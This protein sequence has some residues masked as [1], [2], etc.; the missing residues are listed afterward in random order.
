VYET[1][2]AAEVGNSG[3]VEFRVFIPDATLDPSQYVAGGTPR[4]ARI[5]AVGTFQPTPWESSSGLVLERQRFQN[6]GYLY[7]A[8]T[9]PLATGFYEYKYDV[10]FEN[11]AARRVGDPCTKYGG[12]TDQRA[13]FVVDM[14]DD[15]PVEPLAGGRKPL[16]DLVVY[17]LMIDDFTSRYRGERAPLDALSDKVGHLQ[18][19]GISAVELMPWTAWP[20]D[21]FNW[22]YEP[23][24]Y[25][26]VAHRYT[27]D[28]QDPTNKLVYLKKFINAC[29]RAGIA[30]FMD[31]VFNHAQTEPGTKGF[32][33]YHLYQEPADCPYVGDFQE[34][35]FAHDL[36][37]ANTCTL[38]FI[39]D[40]CKYWIDVF[41]ID[42]IRFDNTEGFYDPDDSSV[43]LARLLLELRK[44]FSGTR[45]GNVAERA[46]FAT[47]LEHSWDYGAI[48]VVNKVG[49]TSCW[50]YPPFG[51]AQQMLADRRIGASLMRA[52]NASRD[53]GEGRI[54]TAFI[55]NHDHQTIMQRAGSRDEWWRTQPWMIALFTMP[56]TPMLHNGQEWGQMEWFPEMG[57][58]EEKFPNVPRVAPRPLNWSLKDDSNGR[59]LMGMYRFLCT[60]RN[61]HPGLRSPGFYPAD[62]QSSTFDADGFGVDEKRQVVVYHRYGPG[63]GG[64][65]EYFMI[66]LNFSP[67]DEG[68][69]L[70]FP[71]NGR[72]RD[73]L[74][75]EDIDVG[76]NTCAF[77]VPSNWGR[78]YHRTQSRK[79]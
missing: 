66:A 72:W 55:E 56:A 53:F 60:L 32:A 78:I 18:S 11:A 20:S 41:K 61:Q 28:P 52:L 54:G 30:V 34:H 58:E 8:R 15:L 77:V 73:L 57:A 63:D 10:E 74:G 37:Y 9:Q 4:I 68:L 70:K 29:H 12:S 67:R 6:R 38:E 33:Y 48:D 49:A 16:R 40:V 5:R 19:L 43:G 75:N 17:E 14:R 1:F 44:H 35:A 36:N 7:S 21:S 45:A 22:G 24:A 13:G 69:T 46:N 50:Y 65:T 71:F 2:G 39:L 64:A 27:L 23:Y 3:A 42:G 59:A 25:F 26:S 51:C 62:W 47:T 79:R 76:G 31:G